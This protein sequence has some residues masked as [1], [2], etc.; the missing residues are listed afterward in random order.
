[1]LGAVDRSLS[2]PIPGTTRPDHMRENAAA[3]Q[4]RLSAELMARVDELVNPRTVAGP[5]YSTALQANIDTELLPGELETA[6]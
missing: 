2:A 3:A 6:E 4:V 1:M 5:R